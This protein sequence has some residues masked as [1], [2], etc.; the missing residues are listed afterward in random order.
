MNKPIY[1]IVYIFIYFILLMIFISLIG[2][3]LTV[4]STFA[5]IMG[6]ILIIFIILGSYFYFKPLNK[7]KNEEIS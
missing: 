5:N 4:P 3:L 6:V 2:T 7:N 1:K